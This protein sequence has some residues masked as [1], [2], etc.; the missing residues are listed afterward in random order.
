MGWFN[1]M[2][3]V[4]TKQ[5]DT[6]DLIC[7]RFYGSTKGVTEQVLEDN[8]FL[9]NYGAVL[10]LGLQIEMPEQKK[11]ERKVIKLWD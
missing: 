9:K 6:V 5:N 1:L 3:K 4:I 11:V 8:R 10:P 2:A 7:K